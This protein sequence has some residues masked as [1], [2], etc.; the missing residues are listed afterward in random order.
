MIWML[1]LPVDLVKHSLCDT[2]MN[3]MTKRLTLKRIYT[4]DAVMDETLSNERL[5]SLQAMPKKT[6]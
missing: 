6:N 3:P 2:I 4:R 1:Q 5:C